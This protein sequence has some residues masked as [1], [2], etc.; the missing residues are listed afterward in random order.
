MEVRL[1]SVAAQRQRPCPPDGPV[2]CGQRSRA[3]RRREQ[4]RQRC[5]REGLRAGPQRLRGR[6]RG[7][8]RP[9]RGLLLPPAPGDVC[10]SQHRACAAGRLRA[11]RQGDQGRVA[12]LD[13]ARRPRP[14]A[15]RRR[16]SPAALRRLHRD[17]R[18]ER[19]VRLERCQHDERVALH[20]EAQAAV[21]P[22][23]AQGILPTGGDESRQGAGP[24][25]R[26]GRRLHQGGARGAWRVGPDVQEDHQD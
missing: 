2:A 26:E 4:Q 23:H 1:F 19:R 14:P 5:W 3:Q 8:P 18:G 24:L 15:C 10:S 6:L 25:S 16:S 12:V 21:L 17:D 9:T 13:G 22:G 7:P 20:S 11:R